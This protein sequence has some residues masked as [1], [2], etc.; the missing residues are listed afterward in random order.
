MMD[1]QN[2][3]WMN[4]F[5]EVAGILLWSMSLSEEFLA[6]VAQWQFVHMQR[7]R[8]SLSMVLSAR[9][10]L[11]QLRQA[12]VQTSCIAYRLM[13]LCVTALSI[14]WKKAGVA[15]CWTAWCLS[16]ALILFSSRLSWMA[17]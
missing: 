6:R 8:D 1:W 11:R 7:H 14:A 16:L 4:R 17:C 10:R 15:G 9:R 3:A 2:L 12:V 5:V 13:E